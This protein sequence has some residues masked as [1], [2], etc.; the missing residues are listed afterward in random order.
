MPYLMSAWSDRCTCNPSERLPWILERGATGLWEP[1]LHVFAKLFE[2]WLEWR[3]ETGPAC[4]IAKFRHYLE[5]QVEAGTLKIEDCEVAAAQFLDSCVATIL[6]PLL[7]NASDAPSDARL[8]HVVAIAVR[9]FLVAYPA[10]RLM[11]TAGWR[12][13]ATRPIKNARLPG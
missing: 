2:D 11:L 10:S 7:F 12:F 13:A 3:L 1:D 4:G 6:K 5:G 9:T 8:D